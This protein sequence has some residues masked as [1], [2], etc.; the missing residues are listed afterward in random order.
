MAKAHKAGEP[1][2]VMVFIPLLPA[3]SGD[4]IE[5]SSAILRIQVNYQHKS[6][7]KGPESLIELLKYDGVP[8]PEKYVKFFSL[9]NHGVT[10]A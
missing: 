6:I 4:I 10:P 1:F 5:S 9:R 3:F 2:F 7:S 8:E